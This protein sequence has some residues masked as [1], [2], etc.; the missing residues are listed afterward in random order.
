MSGTQKPSTLVIFGA[1]G[2]LTQRKLIPALFNQY[3]KGHLPEPFIMVGF[4]FEDYTT[5]TLR[6][7]YLDGM[8]QFSEKSFDEEKWT[9]FCSRLHY[10]QGNL[11]K[12]EDFEQLEKTIRDLEKKGRTD[13]LYYLAIAPRFIEPTISN[14]GHA[15][16]QK[17]RKGAR[18]IIIEKPFGTD[19]ESAT[20]LNEMVHQ[21]FNESQIYRIDHYLGKET[22]QNILFF[23]FANSVFESVW[24][25]QHIDNVQITVAESVDVG[26]RG[27]YYDHAGVMRDMIQNHLL[28]L[29]T[30]TAMEPPASFSADELRNEKV[31]VLKSIRSIELNDA[32]RGQY[33]GYRDAEGVNP[34]SLTPTFAAFKVYVDNWRWQGVPFFLRSGKALKSKVSQ[35]AI[36][37]RLPP[38]MMFD[39]EIGHERKRN[40]LTLCIQPDEGIHFQF[41]T[42]VPAENVK[43]EIVD[44][45][46]HYN[47]AF[48][49]DAIPEAY[50]RLLVD[51][52][53]GDASL[54]IRSDEIIQAWRIV[55]PII[56]AWEQDDGTPLHHY[57]PGSWGPPSA[58]NLL[59]REHFEWRSGCIHE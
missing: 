36:E 34:T 32:V 47:T 46:W 39:M 42:K 45:D 41:E 38:R 4:A 53:H 21:V 28:Q 44:M 1:T 12:K 3:I 6:Q 55:D 50:E 48:G 13:R 9:S 15:G 22:A 26:H 2:D 16:M 33:D 40:V 27:G 23:R 29:L 51:A 59:L 8:H 35:I 18:K 58:D 43:T 49:E 7:R 14:L 37:F 25:R 57:H 56:K 20:E 24:N 10:V 11:T 19:L 30:L 52:L 31:K 54:F 5:D 17:E